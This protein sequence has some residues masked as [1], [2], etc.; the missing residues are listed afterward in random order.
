MFLLRQTSGN[1][2]QKKLYERSL[3]TATLQY[4]ILLPVSVLN[5]SRLFEVI[6]RFYPA[7]SGLD[8]LSW[9]GRFHFNLRYVLD[10]FYCMR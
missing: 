9:N 8:N 4:L 6:S 1:I 7:F 3:H 10:G 2:A 5:S